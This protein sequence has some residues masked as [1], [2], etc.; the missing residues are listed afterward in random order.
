MATSEEDM[1]AAIEGRL[2]DNWSTTAIAYDNVPYTPVAGT[3][4]IRLTIHEVD[5]RQISMSGS[6]NCHRVTGIINIMIF[7]ATGTGTK[8]AKQYADTISGIFRNA[9]FSD[10]L[11][12]SPRV[13]RVGDIG[14]WFQYTVLI[15]FQYDKALANAT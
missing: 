11:C 13:I 2:S 6:T 12:R 5:S 4:Y 1:R 14:E 10:I 3:P 15:D 8:T 7:V 9:D